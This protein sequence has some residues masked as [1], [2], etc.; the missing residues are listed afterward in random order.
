MPGQVW[1]VSADGGYLANSVLSKQLRKVSQPIQKF[2]QFTRMEPGYGKGKGD[3][4]LFNRISNIEVAG[5]TLTESQRIP[6]TKITIGRGTVTV[7]EYGNSIPYTGKLELLSEFSVDNIVTTALRDDMGKVLDAA[8]ADV[9]QTASVKYTPTGTST[10][11][12]STIATSGTAGATATRHVD[13]FDIEEIVDY[14]TQ[15]LFTPKYDGDNY[16]CV[17]SR[18]ALRKIWDSEEF[19]EAAKFGDPER[20]FA[21]EIGRFYNM[22]FVE[23][24]NTLSTTLGSTAYR[25]ELVCFGADPVVEGMALPEEIRAKIPEDYGRSKG[26]AWYGLMGWALT[27]DTGSAG[28]AK[29]VHV[30]SL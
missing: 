9:F 2:R 23:E 19:Q 17:G 16:V 21:G 6:E 28:E 10:N 30:T 8:V 1:S 29:I 27:W 4:I 20:L 22:R 14:M 11:P 7:N 12:T 18:Y 26:V 15:I 25:G 3:T 5:G 13:I 24:T